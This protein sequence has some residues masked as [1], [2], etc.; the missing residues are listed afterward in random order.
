VC[1]LSQ[2]KPGR[3]IYTTI[4]GLVKS[5]FGIERIRH[6]REVVMLSELEIRDLLHTAR[7]IAIVGLSDNPNR[8]SHGVA[9]YLQRNGY[10][11]I[12]VNPHLSTPVLGE[13]PYASLRDLPEPVDL[14]NVF[15]RSEFVPAIVEEAIAVK[16]PV[17]W[18]QLGVVSPEAAARATAAGVRVVMDRCIAIEHRR[19]MRQ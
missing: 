7:T 4:F 2:A 1:N 15:R 10:R 8:D 19:L 11:I 13:Q 9:K 5:C 18:M 6:K 14:V 3:F 12:P 17:I 16:A